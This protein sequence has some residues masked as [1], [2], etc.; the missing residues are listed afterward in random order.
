MGRVHSIAALPHIV[1]IEP[2][3][4]D[5]ALSVGGLL[6]LRR[7]QA[8]VT[9]LSVTKY[10]NYT[11]ELMHGDGSTN[12]QEVTRRRCEETA[13]AASLLGA[14]HRTMEERDATLRFLPPEAWARHARKRLLSSFKAWTTFGSSREEL[15]SLASRIRDAVIALEPDELWVPLGVGWNI[16]HL[17]TRDACLAMIAQ[18]PQTA[19]PRVLLYEDG[20]YISRCRGHA[21]QIVRA[22][23]RAGWTLTRRTEEIGSVFEEKMRVVSVFES[24]LDSSATERAFRKAQRT[25]GNGSL[26]EAV[27]ELSPASRP[28]APAELSY[29]WEL[30]EDLRRRLGPWVEGRRD[31][32]R[33]VV[34]GFSPFGRWEESMRLLLQVFHGATLTVFVSSRHA[35]ETEHWQDERVQIRMVGPGF[36][37]WLWVLAQQL[38]SF[39]TP[40]VVA[41]RWGAIIASMLP[42]RPCLATRFLGDLCVAF[43]QAVE[44][45][46]SAS[47]NFETGAQ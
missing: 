38:L 27:Y 44:P 12:E 40:T 16:D 45:L 26:V 36:L 13:R 17:R 37:P 2:H 4:D 23:S 5:A 6:L 9:I 7:G 10:S 14:E 21:A 47:T 35:W 42:L 18:E 39:G 3:M 41:S 25:A 15:S 32:K 34:L 30:L 22:F 31:W 19:C 46:P 11:K 1:V 33:I 8:R 43:R 29:K 20:A 24:Q 28:P